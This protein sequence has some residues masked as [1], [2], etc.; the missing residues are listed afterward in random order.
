MNWDCLSGRISCLRA[1][2]MNLTRR[3]IKNIREEVRQNVRRLRHHAS[4]GLW[5]GNNEMETQTLDKCWK[6]SEKQKCDYI[7]IFEYIIPQVVKAEEPAGLLLAVLP[8]LRRKLRAIPWDENR[9]DAHYWDVW[10]GEKPFTDYR[11]YRFRYLSEFGFQSFPCLKT[12]E[13][14]TLPEDRNIFSRVMEMHQRNKAANG[15]I[16]NYMAQTYLYPGNFETLLY[17]SQLLQAEAIRYGVEHFRRYRG[18]CM[19]AVVWQLNNIWP[20]ASWQALTITGDGKPC[21]M[22]RRKCLHP[23]CFPVRK[24]AS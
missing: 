9:G 17:A 7:K 13:S 15:K 3:L 6:P 2:P 22:R 19:G 20:V 23:S 18:R 4:I 16:M 21:T 8:V 10:H 24:R 12:V 5:C 1:L 14:F 11:K